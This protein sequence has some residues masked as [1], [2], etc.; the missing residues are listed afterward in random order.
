MANWWELAPV[1][2]QTQSEQW[3]TNAPL[4]SSKAQASDI[5]ASAL[6]GIGRGIPETIEFL[7]AATATLPSAATSYMRGNYKG[8]G[9][10]FRG[11]MAE[12]PVSPNINKV[13]GEPYQPQTEAGR[14]ARA[15]GAGGAAGMLGGLPAAISGVAGGAGGEAGGD[16]AAAT[17]G[18]AY[19][20]VGGVIGSVLGGGATYRYGSAPVSRGLAKPSVPPAPSA[21]DIRAMANIK[22][23][24]AAQK[25]GVFSPKA[26]N[27]FLS[28]ASKQ[29]EA[30]SPLAAKATKP[31]AALSEVENLGVFADKPMT[32]A[33]AQYLDEQI[34][35]SI[36]KFT[37]NGVLKK[38][39]LQLFKVQNKLRDA[40]MG[41]GPDDII[42][43]QEGV[44]ALTEGRK[45]W[46]QQVRL[47]DIEKIITRAELSQNPATAIKTG[48]KNL[49][50]NK[51]R[52]R[53][54]SEAE[55][56]VIRKAA[57]TGSVQDMAATFGTRLIPAI[58][59][60]AGG[61]LTGTLAATAGSMA[62]RSASTAL[63]V[64][65]AQKAAEIVARGGV[66]PS[67]LQRAS[68]L[69]RNVA[70]EVG[71]QI[72]QDLDVLTGLLKPNP[73]TKVRM[74]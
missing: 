59:A 7:G 44:N 9:N 52:M 10:E 37:E 68:G 34:G 70:G 28:E 47:S 40:V 17:A 25:G 5:A 50:L 30:P 71:G 60:A 69:A 74:P 39:G 1:V 31:S 14:Y 65:R 13:L 32:L 23:T 42:G 6:S 64:G 41:A 53:G 72:N 19:R 29:F 43:G 21:D 46:S 73:K 15:M 48:F 26:V 20:P 57:E 66:M 45:L 55:K 11:L 2:G 22:Y 38:E 54:Y 24:E 8:L 3:W 51:D 58:T 63:Q 49:Y 27:T 62:S 18:E 56:E 67:I 16:I 35:N 12:S 33:E 36:D 4:A 61:G